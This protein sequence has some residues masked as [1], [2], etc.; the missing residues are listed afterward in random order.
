LSPSHTKSKPTSEK[1]DKPKRASDLARLIWRRGALLV[2]HLEVWVVVVVVLVLVLV[3]RLLLLVLLLR[4]LVVVATRRGW[5]AG[6]AR[7]HAVVALLIHW[8]HHLQPD[9]TRETGARTLGKTQD[10]PQQKEWKTS[11]NA[12]LCNLTRLVKR[13]FYS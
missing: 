13:I 7:H 5:V 12:M 1:C 11:L 10:T 2:V 4:L 8:R 6:A 9:A 3:L